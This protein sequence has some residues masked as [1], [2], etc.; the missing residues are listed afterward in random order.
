[1]S[2]ID[3]MSIILDE[4]SQTTVVEQALCS[5]VARSKIPRPFSPKEETH[6]TVL[7]D[8]LRSKCDSESRINSFMNDLYHN[9]DSWEAEFFPHLHDLSSAKNTALSRSLLL[10]LVMLCR[11]GKEQLHYSIITSDSLILLLGTVNP[12]NIPLTDS[13]FHADILDIPEILL[14]LPIFG[15]PAN[16]QASPETRTVSLLQSVYTNVLIPFGPYLS[17]L[18]DNLSAITTSTI[19]DTFFYVLL[20]ITELSA[21]DQHIYSFFSQFRLSFPSTG[22]LEGVEEDELL[23]WRLNFLGNTQKRW[24]QNHRTVRNTTGEIIAAFSEDGLDDILEMNASSNP[25]EQGKKIQLHSAQIIAHL[26][27][28]YKL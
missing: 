7:I 14:K 27:G 12:Q 2:T 3:F 17:F 1:M 25:D 4:G 24:N 15:N 11:F 6:G 21:Q 26:G 23:S 9:C 8:W 16:Y 28:N 18:S 10:L 5:L 22:S 13:T 20:W 19:R